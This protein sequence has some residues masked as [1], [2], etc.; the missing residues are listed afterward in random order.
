MP[1][2][3]ARNPRVAYDPEEEEALREIE[4]QRAAVMGA[5]GPGPPPAAAMGA[6][7]NLRPGPLPPPSSQM[8]PETGEEYAAGI[9]PRARAEAGRASVDRPRPMMG[10]EPGE[11]EPFEEDAFQADQSGRRGLLM[12]IRNISEG[13]GNFYA[14]TA[15]EILLKQPRPERY[16][17]EDLRQAEVDVND[18]IG[19]AERAM[20]RKQ[21]GMELPQNASWSRV[22]KQLPLITHALRGRLDPEAM[23]LR[24]RA[25]ESRERKLDLTESQGGERLGQA[26]ERLNMQKTGQEK[27]FEF[28]EQGLEMQQK[29][30][31]FRMKQLG[32]VP[33]EDRRLLG[34]IED[35]LRGLQQLTSQWERDIE[36]FG[37]VQGR[38]TQFARHIGLADPDAVATQS[39]LAY[40]MTQ[41]IYRSTGKQMNEQEMKRLQA[42]LPQVWD[43]PDQFRSV[44]E[45]FQGTILRKRSTVLDAL[46]RQGRNIEG[47]N[48]EG[49]TNPLSEPGVN[50]SEGKAAATDKTGMIHVIG[51]N[52]EDGDVPEGTDLSKYPGWKKA[53]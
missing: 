52:G 42:V 33:D 29:S 39:L 50:F 24:R 26:G 27:G 20:L 49:E 18:E 37:P 44:M 4:R 16:Q 17:A 9:D 31:D 13:L 34:D 46:R 8:G 45:Q 3:L 51:P 47:F 32:M 35:G 43:S 38:W 2:G 10:G 6:P 1:F 12:G 28:R 15:G 5:T 14:P 7:G 19:P 25:Q 40:E 48:R 22:S 23:E 41:F 36:H 11:S 21:W 53:Q 30:I